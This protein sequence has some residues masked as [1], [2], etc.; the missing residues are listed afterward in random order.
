[1]L[2][3]VFI[4]LRASARDTR[5]KKV[6]EKFGELTVGQKGIKHVNELKTE[7]SDWWPKCPGPSPSIPGNILWLIFQR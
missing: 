3:T 5:N 6:L 1:L 4:Q 2:F 7:C